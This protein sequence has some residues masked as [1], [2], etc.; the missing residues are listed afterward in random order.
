MLHTNN[1]RRTEPQW[2]TKQICNKKLNSQ[3]DFYSQ[4]FPPDQA[5]SDRSTLCL[6]GAEASLQHSFILTSPGPPPQSGGG[7]AGP[8]AAGDGVGSRWCFIT[9]CPWSEVEW[10][11]EWS[12]LMTTPVQPEPGQAGNWD[13]ARAGMRWRGASTGCPATL[14]SA[15]QSAPPSS[16]QANTAQHHRVTLHWLTDCSV[17][18]QIK[19]RYLVVNTRW[20]LV[21]VLGSFHF[22]PTTHIRY[23]WISI[24]WSSLSLSLPVLSGH[25]QPTDVLSFY[26]L[27]SLYQTLSSVP[28]RHLK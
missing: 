12:D 16:S 21:W 27:V 7:G 15:I 2:K 18:S 20:S 13:P 3:F 1:L 17:V 26:H 22:L 6:E 10:G 9:V 28:L 11:V 4:R 8:A 24:L 25:W 19:N 5:E 14:Q 23:V